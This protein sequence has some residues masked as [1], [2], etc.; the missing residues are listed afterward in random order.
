MYSHT[1]NCRAQ[2]P[3]SFPSP[4][5]TYFLLDTIHN[6][7]LSSRHGTEQE[8]SVWELGQTEQVSWKK[9]SMTPERERKGIPGKRNGMRSLAPVLPKQLESTLAHMGYLC[10]VWLRFTLTARLRSLNFL[11]F[12]CKE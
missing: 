6:R 4:L 1:S 8:S 5:G 2:L 10:R 9:N 12:W 7:I 3:N 11:E